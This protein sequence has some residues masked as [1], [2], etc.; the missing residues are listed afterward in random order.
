MPYF[1]L[2][3]V[4]ATIGYMLLGFAGLIGM[5]LLY[6][7]SWAVRR[8]NLERD[9]ELMR[10]LSDDAPEPAASSENNGAA[11]SARPAG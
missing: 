4:P 2:D 5:P 7:A 11:S 10:T 9:I 3:T 1:P 6:I 8:R